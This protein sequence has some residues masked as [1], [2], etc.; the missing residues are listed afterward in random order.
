RVSG[1]TI[2]KQSLGTRT[3][4]A[5][6]GTTQAV[7]LNA[8]SRRSTT[9][10]RATASSSSVATHAT[11]KTVNAVLS[12]PVRAFMRTRAIFSGNWMVTSCTAAV[13]VV[14]MTQSIGSTVTQ[15][16]F[17]RPLRTSQVV[18][19]VR[20]ITASNWLAIP[21]MG[22]MVLIDPVQISP[23]QPS[24]TRAVAMM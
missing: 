21:N 16:Y 19:S 23:P 2:P 18:T 4:D 12:T 10:Q 20:A 9:S 17:A 11:T 14:A 5:T 7:S 1:A 8:P 24:T 13:R 22:Q 3:E 15:A 6:M